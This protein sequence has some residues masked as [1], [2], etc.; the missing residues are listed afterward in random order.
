MSLFTTLSH[1]KQEMAWQK[2]HN[3]HAPKRGDLA[4][5]FELLSV[6]QHLLFRLSDFRGAK[7]VGLVFGSFS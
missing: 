3:K 5:D 4:P 1:I 6:D 2:D 7:P